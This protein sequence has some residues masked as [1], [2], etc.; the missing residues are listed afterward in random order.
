MTDP[1]GR[2]QVQVGICVLEPSAAQATELAHA[3]DSGGVD[4]VGIADSP[5]RFAGTYA[6][7]SAVLGATAR[8]RSG[9]MV[10]NAVTCHPAVHGANLAV[11]SELHPG[12]V[13]AAFGTGDSGTAALGLPPSPAT[14]LAAAISTV[15]H[16]AGPAVPLWA[17]AS[18]P[19]TA[20]AVPAEATAIL[21]GCGLQADRLTRLAALAETS[22]G[23]R[24][25]RWAFVVGNVVGT[26]EGVP[27]ARAVTAAAVLAVS[28]HGLGRDPAAAGAPANLVPG[29]RALYAQYDVRAHGQPAGANAAVLSRWPAEA[30]YLYVRFAAIGT[31]A[32]LGPRLSRVAAAAGL[33]GFVFTTSIPDAAEHVRRI[34]SDLRP[35]LSRQP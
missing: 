15:S 26:Q 7:T 34:G 4:I 32:E 21:L 13:L 19:H 25:E 3:A 8:V 28:R 1:G 12:R 18:G 10:T 22:A 9:P 5:A 6:L 27:E 20:A 29:L 30:A 14:A 33:D 24:L 2:H 17:A 23:H 35:L 31:A 11:L 16:R